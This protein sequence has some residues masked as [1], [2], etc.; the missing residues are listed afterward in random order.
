MNISLSQRVSLTNHFFLAEDEGGIFVVNSEQEGEDFL[1][2]DVAAQMLFALIGSSSIQE[3]Y[4]DI[5]ELES[6]D[7]EILKKDLLEYVADLKDDGII[8]V[9]DQGNNFSLDEDEDM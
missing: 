4:E 6:V 5:L 8:Q 7:P 3:A 9:F 2:D 1:L